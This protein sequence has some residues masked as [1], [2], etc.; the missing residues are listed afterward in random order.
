MGFGNGVVQR[1]C[2]TSVK[3]NLYW[4]IK[5]KVVEET[6]NGVRM[7]RRPRKVRVYGLDSNKEVRARLIEI[8]YSRVRYHKDKFIAPILHDEMQHMQV[9]KSGKVE[10]SD[11]THDDQVFSYLMALYV[12]YDG[13]NLAEW[14]IQ[15]NTLKTDE[16]LDFEEGLIE[17]QDENTEKLNLNTEINDEDEQL[18]QDLEW[19]EA[20]TKAMDSK[21]FREKAFF[22]DHNQKEKDLISNS[23]AREAYERTTGLDLEDYKNNANANYVDLPM[24]MFGY[25]DPNDDPDED[26]I[27]NPIQ[28]NL[29]NWWDKV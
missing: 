21:Q 22:E 3:K 20:A 5:D 8:L 13:K 29:S 18:S 10:H 12:W 2:K 15:K 11:Q 7:E 16:D 26:E 6:F 19:V 17:E 4:E 9:K 27:Y 1:L 25:I 24:S 14:G 28:G 23:I